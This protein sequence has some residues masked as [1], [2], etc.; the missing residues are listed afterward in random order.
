MMAR[1]QSLPDQVNNAMATI[2]MPAAVH[3]LTT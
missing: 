1:L 2:Y 3:L